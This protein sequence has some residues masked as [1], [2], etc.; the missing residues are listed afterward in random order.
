MKADVGI[1]EG[2]IATIGKAGNPDLF[3]NVTIIIGPR[4]RDDRG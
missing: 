3:T 1:K 4:H 2:S